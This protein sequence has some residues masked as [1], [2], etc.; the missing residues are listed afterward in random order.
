MS[1]ETVELL[2]AQQLAK[3]LNISPRTLW[4]LKSAGKLPEPVKI[5]GSVRWH[6]KDIQELITRKRKG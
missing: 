4:R 6:P 1:I 3:I 5:G 2:N